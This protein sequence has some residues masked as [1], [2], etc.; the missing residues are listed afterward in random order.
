MKSFEEVAKRIQ[1]LT[2]TEPDKARA[3]LAHA[4]KKKAYEMKLHKG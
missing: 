1:E 3:V 4:A 2:G